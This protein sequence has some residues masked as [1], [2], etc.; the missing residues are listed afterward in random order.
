MTVSPSTVAIRW[1]L[2]NGFGISWKIK[3]ETLWFG[4][5]APMAPCTLPHV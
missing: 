5:A 3:I 2:V 1:E 4:D